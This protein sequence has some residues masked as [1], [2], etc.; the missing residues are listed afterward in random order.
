ML[1]K[2][3]VPLGMQGSWFGPIVGEP[4]NSHPVYANPLDMG[5]AVKGYL[6]VQTASG[7]V[8]GDDVELL[9]FETFV[10]AQLDAE[11][12]YDDLEHNAV[13][14]G[15]T[16]ANGVETSNKNDVA[17]DGGYGYFEP[18][19]TKEKKLIY[20]AVFL[21]KLS[22]MQGSEKSEADTR[23]NDFNPKM[24]AISYKVTTDNIG[25]WRDRAEFKSA[26]EAEAWIMAKFG[27]DQAFQVSVTVTGNGSATPAGTAI[28]VSG[29][30]FVLQLSNVPAALYDNGTNV[31]AQIS[32]NKY[33]VSAVDKPHELVAVFTTE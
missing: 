24:N 6:S 8:S 18:V 2:V 13:V 17:P 20:R 26:S 27:V 16:Y 31:T 11:T 19:L 29:M 23:K 33:T 32:E 21:Y 4:A 22:A 9:H 14:Y 30:D 1:H 5:A 12:T 3:K 7:D 25:D 15:H 10:S 28:V